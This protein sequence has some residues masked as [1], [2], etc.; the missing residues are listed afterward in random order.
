MPWRFDLGFSLNA[1][2]APL[3]TPRFGPHWF[4]GLHWFS[5]AC[6]LMVSLMATLHPT[7]AFA[8]SGLS[9]FCD[10]PRTLSATQND[11]L[12]G[13]AALIRQALA[14]QDPGPLQ[15][16]QPAAAL[17]SRS[18][19][20]LTWLGQRYSHAGWATALSDPSGASYTAVE[21]VGWEV[22]QLYYDCQDHRPRLFDQGL[23]AFVKGTHN[24]DLG[25]V[26]LVWLPPE[27]SSVL[28]KHVVNKAL[29][30]VLLGDTYSANAY[31]FSERYQNCNQWALE[32]LA[33][34]LANEEKPLEDQASRRSQAQAWLAAHGY[35]PSTVRLHF[36]PLVWLSNASPWLHSD[37]HPPS[38]LALSQF[39]VSLPES[40]EAFVHAQ[41]PSAQR[42]ELCHK[43]DL[44]V[45]HRGWS[46]L[47]ADCQAGANDAVLSLSQ[48]F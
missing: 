12:L 17:I 1:V 4:L 25:F 5:V 9:E 27:A 3:K 7:P 20:D 41:W 39:S 36:P 44:A 16:Q 45:I 23:S 28:A 21:S 38:D 42:M 43:G 31:P 29:S 33:A 10:A 15:N 8:F 24:P 47:S 26:S 48:A 34:A 14:T 6:A 18:G 22:R 2:R 46:S 13:F 40:L 30:L 32:I 35:Q 11:R 19:L 37:D